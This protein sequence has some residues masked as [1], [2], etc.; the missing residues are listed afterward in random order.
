MAKNFEPL[1]E[2]KEPFGCYKNSYGNSY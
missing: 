1:F 2:G